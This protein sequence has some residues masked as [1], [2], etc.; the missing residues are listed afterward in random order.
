[1]EEIQEQLFELP[2][3]VDANQFYGRNDSHLQQIEQQCAVRIVARGNQIKIIGKPD[4]VHTARKIFED[5]C[6]VIQKKNRISQTDVLTS[7]RIVKSLSTVP[8]AVNGK[9]SGTPG[10]MILSTV[11]GTLKPRSQGQARLLHS[12]QDNDIIFAIGP[13]GTGKTY[14]AVAMAV[15]LLK[16]GRVK[17]IVLSRPAVEAGESLGFLPGDFRE[18]IEPYLKPLYDALEDML[19]R[20][21]LKKYLDQQIIEILP[22]A[23]MRGR[24]L[25]NAFVILDEAQN[26]TFNQ[27]KMFL[28]R[29]G[30]NSRAVVTGDITQIDLPQKKESG[31]ISSIR[32]LSD[33]KGIGFIYL[34]KEDVV[35][36]QLVQEI[37]EAYDKFDQTD[38]GGADNKPGPKDPSPERK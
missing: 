6:E 15:A 2:E 33:I 14:L 20:D 22:L 11:S 19:P 16:D 3:R 31:L 35:R 30:Y 36:H 13:A 12:L 9:Q 25:N 29:L 24:T 1:M 23:Y 17:K 26:S 37:I 32:I 4:Q 18:K 38:K 5:L 28:T 7:I 34:G 27:M 10:D 21:I 8:A